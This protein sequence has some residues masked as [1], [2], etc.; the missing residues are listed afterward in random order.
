MLLYNESQ[1]IYE[2]IYN[3]KLETISKDIKDTDV[4]VQK[5]IGFLLVYSH[6]FRHLFGWEY[7]R[8]QETC[9]NDEKIQ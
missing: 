1:T 9:S 5:K 3:Q 2:D 7:I 8:I 6:Q 4:L